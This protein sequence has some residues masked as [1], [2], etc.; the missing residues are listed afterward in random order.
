M[1]VSGERLEALQRAAWISYQATISSP[2]GGSVPVRLYEDY[3]L[4]IKL[5]IKAGL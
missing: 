4:A 3:E 1:Q 2:Q 5:G